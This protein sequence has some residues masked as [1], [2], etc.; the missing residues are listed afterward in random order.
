MTA[1]TAGFGS[2]VFDRSEL[3]FEENIRAT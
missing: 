1:T 3:P 2:I